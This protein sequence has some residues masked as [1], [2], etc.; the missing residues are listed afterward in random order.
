MRKYIVIILALFSICAY[1][2]TRNSGKARGL[3]MSLSVG[4]RFP[5]RDFSKS[6]NIGVGFNADLSYTDNEY[7]PLFLYTRIGYEH[8]P[9]TEELYKHSDYSSFSSNVIPINAGVK[10]FL[11]P[12]IEDMVLIMPTIEFGGSVAFYEKYHQFKLESGKKNFI[13]DNTKAGFQIGAGISMFMIEMMGYYNYFLNN[14]Y[15]SVNLSVRMPIFM[16]F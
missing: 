9:G 14:E 11:P 6:Q 16:K 8:Y 2:Q 13:E 5:L 7:L 3:F 15:I 12:F 4:P 1:C 10:I